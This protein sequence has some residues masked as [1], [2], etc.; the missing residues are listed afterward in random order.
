[1]RE[2]TDLPPMDCTD[3]APRLGME[4]GAAV[5]SFR[6]LDE[7]PMGS[8]PVSRLKLKFPGAPAPVA[9]PAPGERGLQR[10]RL[11]AGEGRFVACFGTCSVEVASSEFTASHGPA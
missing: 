2:I 5:V 10:W 8:R 4:D 1:M 7:A 11:Y 3:D 9:G 6:V